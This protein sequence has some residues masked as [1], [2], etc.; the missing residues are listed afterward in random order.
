MANNG[1]K[2]PDYPYFKHLN[3]V[4]IPR[5][6]EGGFLEA[7][8]TGADLAKGIDDYG[9]VCIDVTGDNTGVKCPKQANFAWVV[10]LDTLDGIDPELIDPATKNPITQHT[11][12][13]VS[14]TPTI[15]RGNVYFPIYPMF[16]HLKSLIMFYQFILT[17]FISGKKELI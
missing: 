11:F 9:T 15:F 6:T 13:K 4:I 14:A 8:H 16:F 17:R 7:A 1:I 2:D 3:S 12:R 10:H 5:G